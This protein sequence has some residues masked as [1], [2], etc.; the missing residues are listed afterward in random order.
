MN[1]SHAGNHQWSTRDT[2]NQLHSPLLPLP[3]PSQSPGAR[4]GNLTNHI[5]AN[6]LSGGLPPQHQSSQAQAARFAELLNQL[7]IITST[8]SSSPVVILQASLDH[9]TSLQ[10]RC[11]QLEQE[12]TKAL[13]AFQKL[14]AVEQE[15]ERNRSLIASL[16]S[17]GASAAVS[18]LMAA[19][20]TDPLSDRDRLSRHST[21]H[22]LTRSATH[23]VSLMHHSSTL[24]R[25]SSSTQDEMSDYSADVTGSVSPQTRRASLNTAVPTAAST[26]AFA[27]ISTNGS[28]IGCSQSFAE[29]FGF[30]YLFSRSI[31]G[32][33]NL[34]TLVPESAAHIRQ[35]IDQALESPPAQA[36]IHVQ[37]WLK[38]CAVMMVLSP[39]QNS[40]DITGSPG[41]I[42]DP[43]TPC[44]SATFRVIQMSN[45]VTNATPTEALA[46]H[47]RNS[48]QTMPSVN[49][50]FRS[51]PEE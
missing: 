25:Q 8:S 31:S 18:P 17:N 5:A 43:S 41:A 50:M 42:S 39:M 20:P 45:A 21:P 28:I 9:I 33:Y 16:L 29:L 11:S 22:S 12:Y 35:A 23:P 32:I 3:H 24:S 4:Y 36:I 6:D 40:P 15:A 10:G 48:L 51:L 30:S 49:P 14:V 37:W 13:D 44:L 7:R 47:R 1:P 2:N 26:P 27:T 46:S 34:F 19:S 38:N